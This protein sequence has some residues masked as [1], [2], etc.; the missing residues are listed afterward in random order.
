MNL[1]VQHG[2]GPYVGDKLS[3]FCSSEDG[4]PP[5]RYEISMQIYTK[6]F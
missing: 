5:S 6:H 3:V 4:Y 2:R 1:T